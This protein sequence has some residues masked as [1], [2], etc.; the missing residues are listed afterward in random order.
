[1][2]TPAAAAAPV[3]TGVTRF[4]VRDGSRRVSC[5][6]LDDALGAASGLTG[7]LTDTVRRTS[8][9]RFRTLIDAAAKLKLQAWRGGPG[10]PLVLTSDD[11]RRVPPRTGVPAFGSRLRA[12]DRPAVAAAPA[13][14]HD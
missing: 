1:M 5:V 6:V 7:P 14:R 3:E 11:L 13:T 2:S 10:T 8:F 4:E 9:D 12:L